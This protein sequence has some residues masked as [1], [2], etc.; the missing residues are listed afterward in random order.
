[1]YPVAPAG[2]TRSNAD[3]AARISAPKRPMGVRGEPLRQPE[4]AVGERA[5]DRLLP[6][7]R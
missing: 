4:P 6:Q 1:M 3:S 5:I 2:D 7:R